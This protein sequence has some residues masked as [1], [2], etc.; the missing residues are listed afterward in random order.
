MWSFVPGVRLGSHWDSLKRLLSLDV[1]EMS[2]PNSAK[3]GY[4]ELRP[5]TG[6]ANA[7]AQALSFHSSTSRKKWQ[8]NV[9]QKILGSYSP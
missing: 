4:V 1:Q 7:R 6:A 9:P 3:M 2:F 5:E 8:Q